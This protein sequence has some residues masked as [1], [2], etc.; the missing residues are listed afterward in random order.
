MNISSR[1]FE[2]SKNLTAVVAG[3]HY[4]SQPYSYKYPDKNLNNIRHLIHDGNLNSLTKWESG[5]RGYKK[6]PSKKEMERNEDIN[7]K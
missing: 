6:I 3:E 7:N 4:A 5:L 1:Y 2:Q